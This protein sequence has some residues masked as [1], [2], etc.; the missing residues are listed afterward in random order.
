M[1]ADLRDHCGCD[2]CYFRAEEERKKMAKE[3]IHS[4][5]GFELALSQ[6]PQA[7]V[8]KAGSVR[9]R[10]DGEKTSVSCQSLIKSQIGTE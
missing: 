7:S 1:N 6:L 2:W 5:V 9:S 3:S 10:E 4:N 8:G